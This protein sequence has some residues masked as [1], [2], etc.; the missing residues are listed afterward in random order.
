MMEKQGV[1]KEILYTELRDEEANL[2]QQMQ[3]MMFDSEKTASDKSALENR[4]QAIRNKITE[5]DQKI[6]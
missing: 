6:N 2:M 4:L 1:T 5:L 3:A